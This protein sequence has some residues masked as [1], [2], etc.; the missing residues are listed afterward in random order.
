MTAHATIRQNPVISAPQRGVAL[1]TALI[2][3]VV[4]TLLGLVAMRTSTTELRLARNEQVRMEAMQT[5]QSVVDKVLADSDNFPLTM[6][7]DTPHCFVS[8]GGDVQAVCP[9][10]QAQLTLSGPDQPLPPLFQKGIH[11]EVRR[12]PPDRAPLPGGLLTSMAKFSGAAFAVRGQ[13]SR[14]QAGQGAADIEQ[15]VI[16]LVPRQERI[17]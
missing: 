2:F 13:Y 12:L 7:P 4:I 11:A 16:K 8:G 6:D 10:E 17:Q 1:A 3:L 14:G 9:P 15:G 5:A